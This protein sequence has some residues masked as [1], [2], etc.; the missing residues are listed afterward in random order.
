M[1]RDMKWTST[2][3][4][5][6]APDAVE[7]RD[8][9]VA[10]LASDPPPVLLTLAMIRRHYV[11]LGERTIFRMISAGT[12]P[13]ADVAIGRKLRLWKRE[14]VEAWIARQTDDT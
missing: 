10:R 13:K 8:W 6:S 11:P 1:L 14:T 5:P 12:F 4:Q 7:R 2:V 9:Q 3:I